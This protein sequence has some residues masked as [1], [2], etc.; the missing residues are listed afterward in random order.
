[1]PRSSSRI[2]ELLEGLSD[3]EKTFRALNRANKRLQQ[4]QQSHQLE[5]D[6]GDVDNVNGNVR[7]EPADL[8]VRRV[9]PLVPE[10]ALYDWPIADNLATAIVVPTIQ[11]ETFQITNNMLHLR[12]NKGLFSGSHIEDPQ[13]HLKNFLSICMTQRQPNATPEAIKLLLFPFLVTGEAQT[14]L[15]SLPIN[16]IRTW[17]E[18]VKQFLNKFYPPN[19]TAK[20]I[21]NILQY[22]QQPSESL[23]E[24]W[25]RFKGMLV[26]CPHHGIPN[27]MLGQRFYMGLAD[28]LKANVDA[29]A[30]GAFLSKIFTECKILLDKMSQNLGW[31]TRGTTMAPIVHSVPLDP[32]NLHAENMDTLMTQMS[33]LTKKIDEMST[34]QVHIVDT[35][36]GGLCT[37]CFNQSYVCSWSREGENQG[38]REDMNYVNNYGGQRQGA[39][40]WRPQQ[41]QQYMPNMQ[42]PGG[43][44]PQNQLVPVPY[45]KPQGYPQQNQQQLTYQPPPQQQD[46]NM[47]EIRGMLQQLIGTNNK[48]QEKLAVL[49][50]AIK[51]IETQLDQLSMALNNRPLGTLPADTN[52]NPKDQ[53]PNQ[54]M[55]VSL[56]NGRDLDRE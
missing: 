28:N 43:M 20:Q 40:Q 53:N 11:A 38:A 3:P 25:E 6:M 17:E 23:Q 13:Q 18:L 48:V 8:N 9:A 47:V 1:M 2:G 14:W 10:A 24:T 52:I 49:D 30:G 16:S 45:Q 32:N 22:R 55:A 33:I 51:N 29:S 42:Q 15:N 44:H 19:K 46:N 12:Q 4:S 37:P 36:N 54:L 35:T 27:Q 5:F 34:K 50:S 7:N 31:M 56:R 41:N 21:D 39:H 26:K